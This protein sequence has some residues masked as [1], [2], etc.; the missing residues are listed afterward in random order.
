MVEGAVHHQIVIVVI[1]VAVEDVEY[2]GALTFV[3]R[4][5]CGSSVSSLCFLLRI[6]KHVIRR[7][8]SSYTVL[9]TGLP[10]S[11]SWQDLKVWMVLLSS[12]FYVQ[13]CSV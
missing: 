8:T 4:G 12:L 10:S 7:K 6:Q 9:V 11:A 2:P 1:V 5:F 3:V 13:H